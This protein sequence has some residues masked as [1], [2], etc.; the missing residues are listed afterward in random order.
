MAAT[1][2]LTTRKTIQSA[3]AVKVM[4]ATPGVTTY[5][6]ANF[7]KESKHHDYRHK[8]PAGVG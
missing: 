6:H 4:A 2:A 7:A 3:R 8:E 5:C 1:N